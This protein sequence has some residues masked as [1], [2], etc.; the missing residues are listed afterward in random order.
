M[1]LGLFILIQV[2][3]FV[4]TTCIGYVLSKRRSERQQVGCESHGVAEAT[5]AMFDAVKLGKATFSEIAERDKEV[6]DAE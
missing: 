6:D 2:V 3:I 5:D 4:V 1:T